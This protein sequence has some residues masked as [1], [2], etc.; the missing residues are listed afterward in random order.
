MLA[1]L[2]APLFR[3][4]ATPMASIALQLLALGMILAT[5]WS[6]PLARLTR[7]EIVVLVL[8]ALLPVAYLAPVPISLI[9]TLPGRATYL[10]GL[11]LSGLDGLDSLPVSVYPSATLAG[12]LALLLPIGVFLAVRI[13]EHRHVLWLV[14]L[15][16]AVCV[17]QA[18]L[19]LVQFG[20]A[21]S[22]D[23]L[24]AVPG[25]HADSATGTYPNHNHLA[26]L[27]EMA[28]PL[29]LALLFYSLRSGSTA[30]GYPA[31]RR[32]ASRLP[33]HVNQAALYGSVALLIV[34]GLIFTRS[35]TGILLAMVGIVSS[36]LLFARHLG[37]RSI[38]GATGT[39]V[40]LVLGV[41]IAVGLAPVMDRFSMVGVVEDLRFDIFSASLI[42]IGRMFPI[43]SGPATYPD[44]F[45]A[46]QP[47]ELGRAFINRAHSDYLE[48]LFDV[49]VFAA[50]ITGLI[51]LI[52]LNHWRRIYRQ[53]Q[54]HAERFIQ[55]GAG[56]G[57]ALMALHELLDYNLY[58]PANQ[59]VFALLLGIFLRSPDIPLIRSERTEARR[60]RYQ[61]S[62]AS[63][64]VTTAGA[65]EGTS[66][67]ER[68]IENPFR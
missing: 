39:L 60:D 40:A 1:L 29:A 53:P 62:R 57:V 22:G 31:G 35:R 43:G 19:G 7:A 66:I 32:I 50:L 55:V 4:G 34:I 17:F 24:F 36:T 27:L 30:R 2:L 58:I 13:V 33:L 41:G 65:V 49:G 47:V 64:K 59:L 61:Q 42:G 46:F 67:Q 63:P 26:G 12:G 44:A 15:V 56:I 18:M 23:M 11:R 10:E 37:S 9:E 48:W 45:A 5:L 38:L 25:G 21:Q 20:T 28:L 3:A 8:L 68:Q 54:W 14:Q 16:L 52:Y 51:L 6:A